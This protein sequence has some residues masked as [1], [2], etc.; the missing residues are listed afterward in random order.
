VNRPIRETRLQKKR[1]HT[2][3]FKSS[4]L[5]YEKTR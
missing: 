3:I 1:K 4:A 2:P 5:Y